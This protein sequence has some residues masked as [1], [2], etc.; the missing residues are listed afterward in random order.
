MPSHRYAAVFLIG[1]V[2]SVGSSHAAKLEFRVRELF[3]V[4]FGSG[5]KSL[6]ARIEGGNFLIPR[7][8]SMDG[9]GHFYIYDSNH[10]R[11]VRFSSRGAYEMAINYPDTA[12]QV[13]A[14]AD[15][16]QNLW[17]LISDPAHGLYYGVYDMAG[18]ILR[19]G[20]FAQFNAFHL[21]V[22]D[23]YTLHVI[24]SS[25]RN[26]GRVQT[27]LLDQESL[28]MKKEN[29]ARPPE[30]HHQVKKS[31]RVYFIDPV[32]GA[33]Q[34]SHPVMQIT[35]ERHHSVAS[36][37]G[38]V[39]YVTDDGEVYTRLGDRELNVYDVEG[40]LKG[41]V[42]LKGLSAACAAVRFDSAGNI[43]ELDGIPDRDGH[44]SA[45]MPGMR[46]VEW[47]RQ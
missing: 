47:E 19:E 16:R 31:D 46:L 34:D 13:F 39:A 2:L 10:H 45:S 1:L 7:D 30:D 4:P 18:K 29:T 27:Y 41:K 35:D 8:F 17:L 5:G 42:T 14:H 44:Y 3:R 20:L 26:P 37:R 40:S 36:I 38:T 43:Y 12:K 33:T 9:A 21:H 28:L 25:T 15:S 11:I 23:D 6:G 24:V 22:D 32:P